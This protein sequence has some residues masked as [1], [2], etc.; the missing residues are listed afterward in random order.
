[1]FS[2]IYKLFVKCLLLTLGIGSKGLECT[3][4]NEYT[5]EIEQIFYIPASSL[6]VWDF[7][8]V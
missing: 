8:F 4:V 3:L 2:F 5:R 6:V 1:M 7:G